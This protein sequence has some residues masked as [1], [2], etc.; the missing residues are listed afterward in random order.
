[1]YCVWQ[2][3][4]IPTIISNNPVFN[5][6]LSK[7][8]PQTR[9]WPLQECDSCACVRLPVEWP[10]VLSIESALA[11]CHRNGN[12]WLESVVLVERS[13]APAN[14]S[15]VV[16]PTAGKFP[17]RAKHAYRTR[18]TC[19]V[20]D[21]GWDSIHLCFINSLTVLPLSCRSSRFFILLHSEYCPCA[22]HEGV[23]GYGGL[24]SIMHNPCT[25]WRWVIGFAPR[26]LCHRGK[27]RWYSS[28]RRLDSYFLTFL[29][30][31]TALLQLQ[32]LVR[33]TCLSL[34]K[35]FATKIFFVF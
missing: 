30:H 17:H 10:V 8:C 21:I 24:A 28:T 32:R 18:V 26:L 4:K 12:A 25:R 16:R 9:R 3:V 20:Y 5:S 34:V 23:L 7:C 11:R 2:V 33:V 29:V 15:P 35:F 6:A 13:G 1:M 19:G 14:S 27:N 31:C 22:H